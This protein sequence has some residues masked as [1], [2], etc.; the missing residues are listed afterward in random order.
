VSRAEEISIIRTVSIADTAGQTVVVKAGV[1]EEP[2][3]AKTA[4]QRTAVGNPRD[5][6]QLIL[7]FIFFP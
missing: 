2:V 3:G 5:A 6:G 7:M 4:V 1:V